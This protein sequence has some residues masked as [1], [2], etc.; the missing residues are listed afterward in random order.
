MVERSSEKYFPDWIYDHFAQDGWITACEITSEVEE[1]AR[2]MT[3]IGL[4]CIQVLPINRPTITNLLEM[5]QRRLDE[6]VMPPKQNF[7]QIF[8]D[9]AHNLS[10]ESACATNPSNAKV[11]SE[12]FQVRTSC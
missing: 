9:S 8:K 11:P 6:L 5:F 3:L 10:T 12:V 7:C 2:R 4:W 1:M